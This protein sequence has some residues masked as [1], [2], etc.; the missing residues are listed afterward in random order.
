MGKKLLLKSVN[1][2]KKLA[3]C[4]SKSDKVN[5]YDKSADDKECWGL[6]IHFRDLENSFSK[7]IDIH[8]PKLMKED[9]EATEIEDILFDIGIELQHIHYHIRHT[10]YFRHMLFDDQQD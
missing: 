9:I 5:S 1:D 7:F 10:N 8:L 6:A 4:L 3:V 2:V